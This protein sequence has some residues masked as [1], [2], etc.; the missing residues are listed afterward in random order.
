MARILRVSEKRS[1]TNANSPAGCSRLAWAEDGAAEAAAGVPLL[2][3]PSVAGM[4]ALLS[5]AS[6][7]ER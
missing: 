4:L 7:T 6:G 3:C 5:V 1:E 2:D